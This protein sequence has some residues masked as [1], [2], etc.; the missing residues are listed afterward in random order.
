[1]FK[2]INKINIIIIAISIFFVQTAFADCNDEFNKILSWY[3]DGYIVNIVYVSM[4]SDNKWSSYSAGNIV[5]S[6]SGL[7]GKY[8]QTGELKQYFSDRKEEHPG[9]D[10]QLFSVYKPDTVELKI[11]PSIF[12]V[13]L[14]TWGG[15]EAAVI[16]TCSDG[17]M[18]GIERP[19]EGIPIMHIVSFNKGAKKPPPIY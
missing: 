3:N 4:R 16:P 12:T 1:M 14:I 11:T 9:K 19:K 7:L 2:F 8:I 5:K 13:K 10:P 15:G 17:F 6:G 18:W